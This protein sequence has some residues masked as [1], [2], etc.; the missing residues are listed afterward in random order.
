MSGV[1]RIWV[2]GVQHPAFR[3]GGW[4]FVRLIE[5][6]LSGAAG[7]ERNTTLRRAALAG[8]A[9]ALRDLPPNVAVGIETPSADLAAL[10]KVLGGGAPDP[11]AGPDEDLDRLAPILAVA[12]KRRIAVRPVSAEPRTPAAFAAAW[13]DLAM[14]KAKATGAFSAAIPKSNLAKLSGLETR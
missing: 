11:D 7:G 9:A 4:A 6:Q 5:G 13:A 2:C 1:V 10:A 3:C 12:S 14:D 8:L